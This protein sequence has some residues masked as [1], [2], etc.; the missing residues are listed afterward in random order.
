MYCEPRAHKERCKTLSLQQQHSEGGRE[1]DT[2]GERREKDS[3]WA[4][5]SS[6]Q[7]L[8]SSKEWREGGTWCEAQ[9]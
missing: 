9:V 6:G 3:G 4:D 8:T 1:G 5:P 2:D 7:R